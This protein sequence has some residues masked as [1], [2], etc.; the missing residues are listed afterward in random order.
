MNK[1]KYNK[2]WN[3]GEQLEFKYLYQ[4]VGLA[5]KIKT[6][7]HCKAEYVVN[8]DIFYYT[9]DPTPIDRMWLQKEE[10]E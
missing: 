6:C 7:P 5:Q 4:P 1:G 3:C 2:C 10:E 9:K 8:I